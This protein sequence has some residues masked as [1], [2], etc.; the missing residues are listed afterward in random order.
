[1]NVCSTV[2][3]DVRDDVRDDARGSG[4]WYLLSFSV[5]ILHKPG[6]QLPA[7]GRVSESTRESLQ[8]YCM[9]RNYWD[10]H[11]QI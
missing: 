10:L 6:F 2:Q 1:M 3:D 9:M 5:L 4:E 7:G 11:I 8:Q